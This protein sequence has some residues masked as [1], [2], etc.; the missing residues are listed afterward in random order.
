MRAP[1]CARTGFRKVQVRVP[2]LERCHSGSLSRFWDLGSRL[3]NLVSALCPL[4]SALCPLS[5]ILRS[6]RQSDRSPA[7]GGG[8]PG[9]ME[10][11][12]PNSLSRENPLEIMWSLFRMDGSRLDRPGPG[13]RPV[14]TSAPDARW[15]WYW[16][17][18]TGPDR[19]RATEAAGIA[20]AVRDDILHRGH[21]L[22][23]PGGGEARG[24]L[25]TSPARR[26][27]RP[28]ERTS[29]FDRHHHPRIGTRS[30]HAKESVL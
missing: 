2:P 16:A 7:G 1:R 11:A 27:T 6:L 29:P 12:A 15:S 23:K 17:W 30:A 18:T 3:S 28:P 14:V 5:F 21:P 20:T 8:R 13:P 9:P 26:G 24:V 4:S 10:K 19:H 22:P 25:L